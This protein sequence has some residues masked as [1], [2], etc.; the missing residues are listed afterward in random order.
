MS[1]YVGNLSYDV[2]EEDLNEVFREYG[3]VKRVYIPTDKDTGK[4]RGYAF[5]EMENTEEEKAAIEALDGAQW[6]G[7]EMR[8]NEAKPRENNRSSSGG[9]RSRNLSKRN[10]Y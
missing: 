8:V 10:S 5:V 3:S 1:I 2:G 4:V 7:R 6:Y 9:N